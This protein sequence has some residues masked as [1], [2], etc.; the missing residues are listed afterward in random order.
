[1]TGHLRYRRSISFL[2]AALL[3]WSSFPFKSNAWALSIEDEWKMGQAFF[4]QVSGQ[5]E[6]VSDPFVCKYFNDLG[7]YLLAP[8]ETKPFPFQFYII[9]DDTLNAFAGP[10][11]H[12]FFYAGLIEAMDRV[13]ELAAIVCHEIGHI[14]A[15]HLSKRI[16]QS[17]DIGV[18]T[19]AGI[20]AGILIGGPLA[21]ALITG[22]MA[23][24]MQAQYH[25]SRE[26]ERQA[27]QLSYKYIR[28]STFDSTAMITAL[29]KIQKGSWRGTGRTPPYLLTH[30]TGPER[31]SNLESLSSNDQPLTLSQEAFYLKA[32]FPAFR[33][34]VVAICKEPEDAEKKFLNTLKKD[35]EAWLPQLG[36]GIVFMRENKYPEAIGVLKKA[37]QKQPEF[38]PILRTL[39]EAYLMDGQQKKAVRVLKT[40]LELDHGNKATLLVL[41]VLYEEQGKTKKALR[42]FKKLSYLNPVKNGVYYHLGVCYGRE[43][44]LALAHYNF[45]V[46]FKKL[47]RFQKAM[48]HFRKAKKLASENAALLEKI[49]KETEGVQKMEDQTKNGGSNKKGGLS[50]LQKKEPYPKHLKMHSRS[51]VPP[52]LSGCFP[53][54]ER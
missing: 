25:F 11:G 32:L 40:A 6:L 49:R 9:N 1:M 48:F 42:I 31:M 52:T 23:A 35:P 53:I 27:D 4:F 16:D 14:A 30:P 50:C 54:P 46:Y 41:G 12:I 10:G 43:K 28:P 21:A 47:G 17:K 29:E 45:G 20:L 18:G 33:T 3:C 24:G 5:Y 2:I 22:T 19:M 7:H 38:I 13:D 8:L 44:Q 36:L 51:V 15:R 37:R 39:G 34:L 26:D